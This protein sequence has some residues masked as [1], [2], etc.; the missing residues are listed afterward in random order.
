[1]ST[2][3]P[4]TPYLIAAHFVRF[5]RAAAPQA[6]SPAPGF[7]RLVTGQP[8]PLGNM[9]IVD[10]QVSPETLGDHL[11][12]LCSPVL[13]TA[14]VLM[15][16]Q[17]S[18]QAAALLARGF[19][20][21]ESMPLMSVTPPALTATTLPPGYRFTEVQPHTPAAAAWCEAMCLGY[22]LPPAVGGLFGP[23]SCAAA[24]APGVTRH[25][26]I[27]HE[28]RMVATSLLNTDQGLAGIYGVATLAEHRG[29]G[30]G[31][32]A[33]AQALRFAWQAGFTL[34]LLQA[35]AM[36]APIYTRLGFHTHAIMPLYVRMP[37]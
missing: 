13:P 10:G 31:A 21:A 11:E 15:E 33:T 28:G 24:F 14:V 9:G 6:D 5:F 12:P 18:D 32:H 8:H 23:D 35:S 4:P 36:G 2:T 26:A 27:T 30:L 34:G 25:F 19:V 17:R 29:Q 16:E 1:M 37:Q 22:G 7:F 20:L 3:T